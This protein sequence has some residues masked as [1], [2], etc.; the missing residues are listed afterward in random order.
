[1]HI[2]ALLANPKAH[3]QFLRLRQMYT[4]LTTVQPW[5]SLKLARRGSLTNAV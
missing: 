2:E 4:R 3:E 5:G 1:M